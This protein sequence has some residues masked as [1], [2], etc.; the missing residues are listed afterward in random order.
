MASN[1]QFTE[2]VATSIPVAS[3]AGKARLFKDQ[4]DGLLKLKDH[5]GAVYPVAG[6]QD[7]KDAVRM[8][9]AAALPAYTRVGNIITADAFGLIPAIDGVTPDLND[10][11]L[12]LNGAADADNGV[13]T[14]TQ[15]GS[16]SL[17]FILERRGDMANSAQI[18]PGM[19]VGTGPEGATTNSKL[20]ILASA[21]P[22]TLNTTP[23]LFTVI[24]GE[25]GGGGYTLAEVT[26]EQLIPEKQ[27]MVYVDDVIIGDGG[28]LVSEGN[29]TPG[30]TEDN[31]SILYVPTRSRRVVQENDQMGY[32]SSMV[33][34]G[35]L[36]V[37]GD[38]IDITP[39]DGFDIIAALESSLPG[40]T[41]VDDT[42]ITTTA[43]PT[44]IYS[45]TTASDNR[46][47]ALD[48]LVEAQSNANTDTALFMIAAVAHR[49][50]GAATVTIKDINFFNGP[51]QDAGAAAWDVTLTAP[52]GGPTILIQVTG[53]AGESIDWRVTGKVVEH[54]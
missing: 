38:I 11:F 10:S 17:P 33:V 39:Y 18:S 54:G 29:A 3:A 22:I 52:G 14:I 19:V 7:W 47:I 43:A 49:A 12:F 23:L 46:I 41:F 30:R 32:T 16:G 42:V 44:T 28:D 45:Y 1:I 50:A 53:D 40:Q 5:L 35:T 8:G 36:V 37:D 25:G 31:F 9:S 15:L 2:E 27:D 6:V 48:I 4:A 34:D 21:A 20:Y 13:W 24:S 26:D 51:F